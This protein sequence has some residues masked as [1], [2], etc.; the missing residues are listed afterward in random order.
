MVGSGLPSALQAHRVL[1]TNSLVDTG[2]GALAILG[3]TTRKNTKF[4]W[5]PG[6]DYG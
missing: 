6:A 5:E 1:F 4:N 2:R 3:G